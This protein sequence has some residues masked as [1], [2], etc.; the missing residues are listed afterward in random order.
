MCSLRK[1]KKVLVVSDLS[2][3]ELRVLAHFTKDP[4]LLKA[5]RDGISL[6]KITAE[7][8][9]GPDY[10]PTQYSLAKNGNFA[11][12]YGGTA[13]TIA[14]RYNFPLRTAEKVIIGFYS[15]YRRVQPWKEKEIEEAKMRYK[16]KVT[17]PYVLTVLGRKRR[18]PE[19]FSTVRGK[20]AAAERQGISS[21]IQGSAADLF[22]I[23]M[24]NCYDALQEVS[25]EG[26]LLMMVH[27]ELVVEVPERH[28]EEGLELVKSSMEN[29]LHPQTGKPI[30]SL[31]IEAEAKIVERWSD[32]K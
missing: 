1:D 29:V 13:A 6:H 5:Y 18:L 24:T 15:T 11:V 14:R 30:L 9:F 25:W 27:D 2:Q 10:T 28:A 4:T 31:P 19:L 21:I 20:R 7:A 32:A 8:V 26:H 3:I 12:T 16:R 22:K 23:G 17:Q